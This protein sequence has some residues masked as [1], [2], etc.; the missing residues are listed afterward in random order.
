MTTFRE[1]I[2]EPL[3]TINSAAQFQKV[4]GL[5]RDAGVH[6]LLAELQAGGFVDDAE[7]LTIGTKPFNV[8]ARI[9]SGVMVQPDM[10]EEMNALGAW[11]ETFVIAKN[12]PE[13]DEHW[14]ESGDEWLGKASMAQR[15][16][17]L[18]TKD[19]SW[20]WF[21]V[22]VF[23]MRDTEQLKAAVAVLKQMQAAALAFTKARGWSDK[24]G[25]YMHVYGHASVNS[26]HLHVVDL[27]VAGPTH[28]HLAFKNL[29]LEIVLQVLQAELEVASAKGGASGGAPSA[30]LLPPSPSSLP[31]QKKKKKGGLKALFR[32]FIR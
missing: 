31:P 11:S 22:L 4:R 9:A 19:L 30:S 18:T 32:C 28:A 20:W 13:C 12:R 10:E 27:S 17:F 14:E 8:F 23:G 25:L 29:P 3:P 26:L 5:L 16:R 24:I 15:H 2:L 21:N 1:R 7:M 6:K